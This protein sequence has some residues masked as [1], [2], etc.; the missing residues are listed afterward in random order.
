MRKK[1]KKSVPGP[2]TVYLPRDLNEWLRLYAK[3][4]GRTLTKQ[5]EL[6]LRVGQRIVMQPES[7]HN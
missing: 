7:T 6:I 1:T 3:Q 5:T 4:E 2:F